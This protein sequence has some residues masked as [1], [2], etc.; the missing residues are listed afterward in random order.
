MNMFLAPLRNSD[1]RKLKQRVLEDFGLSNSQEP[2]QNDGIDVGDL[3]VPDGL[4]SI[5]FTTHA[6]EIG[7]R[8]L[9]IHIPIM[10]LMENCITCRLHTSHLT[11]IH[12]GL[13]LGRAVQT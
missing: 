8:Y 12:S 4:Q 1:R 9:T 13:R 7:V 5:K 11:E 2:E 10:T 6:G 3:L